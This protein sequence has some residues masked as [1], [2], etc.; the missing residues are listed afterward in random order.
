MAQLLRY[1]AGDVI[2]RV[3]QKPASSIKEVKDQ[4]EIAREKSRKSV[5][6]LIKKNVAA[7]KRFVALTLAEKE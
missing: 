4:V 1:S 3:N 5:L 7:G 2:I 6:L